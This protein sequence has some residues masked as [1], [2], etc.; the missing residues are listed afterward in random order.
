ML[1]KIKGISGL[2]AMAVGAVA[3]HP[4]ADAAAPTKLTTVTDFNGE[5]G[6]LPLNGNLLYNGQTIYGAT[7]DSSYPAGDA[8]TLVS[9]VVFS[10]P[11]SIGQSS[12]TVVHAFAG[13]DGARPNGGLV[14]DAT[15]NLYG[16]TAAG[17]A[18]GLGTVFKLTNPHVAG[19]TWTL[20]TLHSFAGTSDGASP[21]TGVSFGPDGS[22]YGATPAGGSLGA[23][24]VYKVSPAGAY[25]IVHTFNGLTEGGQPETNVVVDP[26]GNIVGTLAYTTGG[27]P[28]DFGHLFALSPAGAY[29][30]ISTVGGG[31][32]VGNIVRDSAGNVYGTSNKVYL[33]PP[34]GAAIWRV[35]AVTHVW[36]YLAIVEGQTTA[37]GLTRD[38]AGNFY[39]TTT[40]SP[41]NFTSVRS[42]GGTVFTLAP[43]G[44]VTTLATLGFNNQ[45]PQGGVILDPAGNLWGTTAAGG[46]D[47]KSQANLT[48]TGCGTLFAL[49]P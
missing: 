19:G 33:T 10:V 20:T 5:A 43:S 24:T 37:G 30:Y 45:S 17:G 21:I 38:A 15:G 14:A 47:C 42:N 7:Y 16:T 1:G 9:G 49:S 8:G 34:F 46:V 22:I 32:A 40:G 25:Q 18:H 48:T 12:P 3:L 11:D 6:A 28:H 2:V 41:D 29:H 23:G 39:A 36:S 31:R 35:T 44:T 13:P 26:A 27:H 4:G